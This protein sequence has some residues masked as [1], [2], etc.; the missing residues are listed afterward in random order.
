MQS[1]RNNMGEAAISFLCF[2]MTL[3]SSFSFFVVAIFAH[4]QSAHQMHR[5]SWPQM[6]N[7]HLP[8]E[9]SHDFLGRDFI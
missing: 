7:K 6:E 4:F 3:S 5:F 8:T 2:K 1:V 9:K